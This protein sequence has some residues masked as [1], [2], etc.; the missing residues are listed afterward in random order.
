MGAIFHL[1]TDLLRSLFGARNLFRS[2]SLTLGR[3][4]RPNIATTL[5]LGE[6]QADEEGW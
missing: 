1:T 5:I 6:A 4:R 3:W 2:R